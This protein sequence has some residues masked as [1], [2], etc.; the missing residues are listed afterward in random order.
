MEHKKIEITNMVSWAIPWTVGFMYTFGLT[1]DKSWDTLNWWAKLLMAI[2][3]YL[4]WPLM[5]GAH[6]NTFFIK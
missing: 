6:Y 1:V 4:V 5:L 3:Y 2:V